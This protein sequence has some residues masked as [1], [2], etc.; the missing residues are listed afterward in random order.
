MPDD[1]FAALI[2]AIKK[3]R[4]SV[5]TTIFRFD[6]PEVEQALRAAV[7]R[8]VRVRA[9]IAHTNRGGEKSLRSLEM[10]LL[11]AGVTV[12]RT[13]DDLLRYHGKILILDNAQVA[14]MLF[15]Y[16]R[17]DAQSRSFAV[18]TR[19]RAVVAEVSRVFEA[20]MAR[21]RYTAAPKSALVVSPENARASLAQFLRKAKRELCIYDPRV[22]DPAM[23]QILEERVGKGVDV[24]IIGTIGKRA[25]RLE[26]AAITGLRLHARVIIR[27]KHAAFLG[28][29]SLRTAELDARREVGVF[30]RDRRVVKALRDRFE[31]DWSVTDLAEK[32]A[33]KELEEAVAMTG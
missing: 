2:T 12:A 17:L 23:V 22:S 3:A 27:D 21:Q 13:A 1:G 25:R 15:N 33:E 20:D 14:V 7:A 9:L 18:L 19:A 8:G 11:A 32:S 26:A 28:S 29:Q 4:T 24:R 30:V 31:Q 5:D 10:R 6:R 16:T